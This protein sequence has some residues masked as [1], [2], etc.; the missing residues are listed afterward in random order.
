MKLRRTR[1]RER[2]RLAAIGLVALYTVTGFFILP[3]IVRSLA[4]KRLTAELGRRV[5][6]EKLRLNPYTLSVTVENFAVREQD[7]TT[8]FVGWKRLYANFGAWASIR[9]EWVLSEVNLE[10]FEA[11]GQINPDRSLNVSD[12]LAKFNPPANTSAAETAPSAPT[13]PGRPLRIGRLHVSGARVDIS[14]LSRSVPFTTTLGPLTFDLTEFRTVSPATERGAPYRFAAVTEAGEKLS[15]SGTLR[16]EPFQSAGEL[17]LEDIVLSKYAAFYT[18]RVQAEIATGKLSMRARYAIDLAA[19]R[20]ALLLQQGTVQLREVTLR[21]RGA[22]KPAIELPSL[23]VAGIEI[24]AI[25]QKAS[26]ASVAVA[27][28]HLRARR[29]KDGSV[30]LLTLLSA[31]PAKNSSATATA[32]SPSATPAPTAAPASAK[33]P[34]VYVGEFAVKDFQVEIA[35]LAAPR[36]A[37]LALQSL[38]FSLKDF[39]LSVDVPMPMELAFN[40]APQGTVRV[41][42]TVGLAP[43]RAKL[44]ADIAGFEILPLSPYLE[45]FMNARLTQ[46]TVGATLTALASLPPGK[47][48]EATV[49]G[50]IT[51]EKLGLVD[52]AQNAELAGFSR[53][54]LR[55]LQA[56]TTPALKLNLD[57]IDLAGPY[58]R[59]VVGADRTLN[60]ATVT[61]S[62]TTPAGGETAP[63]PTPGLNVPSSGSPANAPATTPAPIIEIGRIAISDGD[64]RFTDRSLEPTVS[65]AISQFSGAVA[66]LSSTNLAKADV[67]LKAVVDGA[68]PIAITGKLDPLGAKP[69]I[70]LKV[71]VK[72]VDLLPLSPYAAKYA[73]YDLARGKLLLEV[74]LLVDGKKIDAN[75]VVTLNQFTFGNAVASPDATKLPVRL[76]VALLK[77]RDGKIVIDIPV[78]G[79]TDDPSFRV[80]R[81]VM[82]VIVNLLTKAATS[83]FSLLGAAFGGGEELAFQEFEPGT[84]ML[85][86][87]EIKKLQ[88]LVQALTNRPALSL[89]IE[90]SYD[91]AADVAALQHLK[92]EDRVRRAIWEKKRVTDPNI[93]PPSEL[94][95][96]TEENLAEL[97]RLFDATFPPGSE[98]G[99]PVEKA[100][101]VVA[102]PPEPPK[103]GIIRRT[104][105]ALTFRRDKPVAPPPVTPPPTAEPTPATATPS[106][107]PEEM[108]GRLAETMTVEDSDLRALAQER[109]QAVRA[110]FTE[111]GKIAPDRLFLSK[112]Q[113]DAA[114]PAK[115]ARVFLHLQ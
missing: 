4:E 95:T 13:K 91:P 40:W 53:L 60:L 64:F 49:T 48:P 36:T 99:L 65:M 74:K 28:G 96:S 30:N 89:N 110:Y 111:V 81:V 9:R 101:A 66:G 70:D 15:W 44:K 42:G 47:P 45:H 43:V 103:K 90:G 58:A 39:T 23:D 8:L 78:Q 72:N 14:D 31:P 34:D 38:Q 7:G 2:R 11:R 52:G 69:S 107:T 29:E 16:A 51:V 87:A 85:Q 88:T 108:V 114:K 56:T 83:P 63:G 26:V 73:G 80:G 24:D 106:I 79:N 77:D 35:D 59:A 19:E 20:K 98:G 17:A 102:P 22:E 84:A 86:E 75:N 61:K 68:G 37:Q 54:T 57:E 105:D 104:I 10:G 67:I 25:E 55:G 21:E 46:G 27:G 62:T 18:D 97:R 100:P 33:M 12:L 93:P 115:G 76:G 71:D 5:T 32:S 113:T 6:I 3:P 82:R 109:A 41:A 94:V 92:L 50:D 112:E 1:M